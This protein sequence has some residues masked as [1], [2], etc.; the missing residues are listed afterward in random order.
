M[1]QPAKFSGYFKIVEPQVKTALASDNFTSDGA[2]YNST[3]WYQRL[4]GGSSSRIS[5]YLDYEKMNQDIDVSRAMDLVAEEMTNI[6]KKTNL[7]VDINILA[8]EGRNLDTNVIATLRVALKHW[9]KRHNMATKLF[10]VCRKTVLYGDVFFKRN[11]ESNVETWEYINPKNVLAVL[12]DEKNPHIIVAYQIRM[13]VQSP[14]PGNSSISQSFQTELYP[15]TDI[16]RFTL[17]DDMSDQMPFGESVLASVYRVQRQ[18]ELLED[19]IIIYRISRAPERRVFYIDVGKM[20]PNRTGQYLEKVKNEMK[21]K[22]VPA[23][24][25]NGAVSIDSTY[26]PQTMSE[27]FYFASR[28][29]GAGNRVETLP[30]GQ[31]LGELT[32]LEYFR[33]KVLEGL[34]I[35]PSFLPNMQNAAPASF[36][37]GQIGVAY[38]PEIQFY[39]YIRRLQAHV[40]PTIDLEFKRY[41]KELQ[42]NI[43]ES[44]YEI[45]LT[46]P[47]NFEKYKEAAIDSMLLSQFGNADGVS[48]LAKRFILSR[49]LRLSDEEISINQM[50][51]GQE[52]GLTDVQLRSLVRLYNPD[53]LDMDHN[54][55]DGMGASAPGAGGAPDG[56]LPPD[57]EQGDQPDLDQEDLQKQ[58]TSN[59]KNSNQ[60][61]EKL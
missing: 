1:N 17:N 57:G 14:V 12:V 27:D 56:Q 50:Y 49:Y 35:P 32:D 13:D 31:N 37:D 15:A 34:R 55:D 24:G 2:S 6:N 45:V 9:F 21:Q 29:G 19:A 30:G 41:L 18:K 40:N 25:S 58:D 20:P 51:L 44:L 42:I 10:Q 48:Y 23:I 8:E 39:K 46:E 53:L 4:M 22:K 61:E 60:P 28:T 26:N 59:N 11:R 7:P 16:I 47:T 38:L 52:R 5:R 33:E 36:N 3:T 43:D 54:E